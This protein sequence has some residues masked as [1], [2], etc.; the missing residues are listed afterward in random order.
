MSQIARLVRI[1]TFVCV[2]GA[3]ALWSQ[4]APP[5]ARPVQQPRVEPCWQVAGISRATMQERAALERETRSQIAAVCAD[6]A[7]TPQQRRQQIQQIRQE[8]KQK[9]EALIS[10]SQQETLQACQK[11]RAGAPP[12]APP[13]LHHGGNPGPC[14]EFAGAPPGHPNPPNGQPQTDTPKENESPQN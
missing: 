4:T 10:P 12:T 1:A 11:E 5:V 9:Q 6:S 2:L 3:S 7:L 14:G 8:S 13:G